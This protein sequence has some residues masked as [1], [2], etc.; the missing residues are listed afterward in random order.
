MGSSIRNL[1]PKIIGNK[2]IFKYWD[3]D[4]NDFKT[5]ESKVKKIEINNK[6]DSSS[7]DWVFTEDGGV[8]HLQYLKIE[9]LN[10]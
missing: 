6:Y 7:L 10:L 9:G 5:I 2:T 1:Y 3:K 8:Y 4:L